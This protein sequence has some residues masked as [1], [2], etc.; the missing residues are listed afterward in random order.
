MKYDDLPPGY[1]PD[2][3]LEQLLDN[4]AALCQA[5]LDFKAAHQRGDE[6]LRVFQ[7]QL[8]A[9]RRFENRVHL[10]VFAVAL[11]AGLAAYLLYPEWLPE[12]AAAISSFIQ[13]L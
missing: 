8:D 6:L 2:Q 11:I 9:N 3:A 12:H 5:D 10:G 1:L 4:S 7:A 13:H